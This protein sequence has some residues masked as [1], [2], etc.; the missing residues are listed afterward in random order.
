MKYITFITNERY[1][2]YNIDI[3]YSGHFIDSEWKEWAVA[4]KGREYWTF[5]KAEDIPSHH[6]NR[7]IR[8]YFSK[9]FQ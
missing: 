9:E 8:S 3:D 2:C 6:I 4:L 5:S 7:C 1:Y